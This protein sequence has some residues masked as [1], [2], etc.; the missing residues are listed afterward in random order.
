MNPLAGKLTIVVEPRLSR[1]DRS[2]LVVQPSKM[3]GAVS[4]FLRGH[5]APFTDTRQN[6]DTD[7][8]EF[9]IRHAFGLGWLEWR[10][11]T[12]LDHAAN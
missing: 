5:E 1:S 2:W 12:R 7:A 10:S 8:L 11:W 4:V 3:D 6:W 9:K